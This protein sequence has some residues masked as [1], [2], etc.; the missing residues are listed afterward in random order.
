VKKGEL[1]METI[2]GLLTAIALVGL[3]YIGILVIKHVWR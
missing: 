3:L 2:T 1:P